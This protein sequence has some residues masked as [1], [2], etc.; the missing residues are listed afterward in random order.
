MAN[1]HQR[2]SSK[3]PLIIGGVAALALAAGTGWWFGSASASADPVPAEQASVPGARLPATPENA[4]EEF[5]SGAI[6]LAVREDA[7]VR[8]FPS[9][10]GGAVLRQQATG[11]TVTGRWVR[12]AD[13]N[14]RWFRLSNGGYLHAS[15]LNQPAAAQSET[16]AP[17]LGEPVALSISNRDCEWGG[18]LQPYYDRVI[19]QRRHAFADDTVVPEDMSFFAPVPNRRWRGLTV[20]GVAIHYESTSIYFREPVAVVRRALTAAGVTVGADGA[21]PIRSEEAVE[22]QSIRTTTGEAVRYGATDL[23]CGV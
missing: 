23:N 20:T 15:S 6:T 5:L 2:S 12:G 18:G 7:D 13:P 9:L 16:P 8:D 10:S 17:N 1:R 22:Y 3:A 4:D 14:A 21:I 19:A 11:T